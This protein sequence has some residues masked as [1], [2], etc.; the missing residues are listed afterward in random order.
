MK[1][2][3]LTL[4]LIKGEVIIDVPE[5]LELETFIHLLL[6]KGYIQ[7][8]VFDEENMLEF[9]NP[10]LKGESDTLLIF[11][12]QHKL[13][14]VKHTNVPQYIPQRSFSLIF[15]EYIS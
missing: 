4:V 1:H 2:L 8:V 10:D 7:S 15:P 3:I 9:E 13:S 14:S 12:A 6:K 11:D 5:K